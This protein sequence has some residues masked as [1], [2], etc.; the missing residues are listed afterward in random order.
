MKH[1]RLISIAI[2]ASVVLL[3]F[4]PTSCRKTAGTSHTDAADTVGLKDSADRIYNAVIHC[5]N[6]NLHDS[7]V[8]LVPK[9]ME[10]YQRLGLWKAFYNAWCK[11]GE[12]Y[13]WSGEPDSA[14]MEAQ[15]IH[16]HAKDRGDEYGLAIADYIKGLVYDMQ[17]NNTESAR[18][19]EQALNR[20]KDEDHHLKNNIFLYYLFELKTLRDTL[21]MGQAFERWDQMIKTLTG[22]SKDWEEDV[23]LYRY[24]Y[25]SSLVR[26]SFLKKDHHQAALAID[27]VSKYMEKLGWNAVTRN[28]V[29]SYRMM[30]AKLEGD[31]KTALKINDEMM[32]GSDQMEKAAQLNLF[33]ERYEILALQEN[34][35]DAYDCLMNW[36]SMSDSIRTAETNEQ[37]NTLNKRFELDELKMQAER[38]RMESRQRQLLLIIAIVAIV[39]AAVV[40]YVISRLRTARRMSEMKAA[41]E[42]IESELRIA[43]DIQMSMVPSVFPEREGLDMYASMTPAKEVGGDL[44]GYVLQGDSLYIGVGDVSGKGVPASLFMAQATRLFRT[45]ATQD[46]MPAEI[47]TRMNNALSGDD[48]Q[49][50]MFVTFFIGLIDLKTGHMSFCNAG[51]NPPVIGGDAD[52][53][54]FLQME[55]NAP[56]GLWPELEY[57]GEEIEN[58]KGHPLFIYTDGLNEAENNEQE[59]FGDDRLLSILRQTQFENARQVVETLDTEVQSHRNGAE[60]NDDLTMM[61]VRVK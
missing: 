14:I 16:D 39:V 52:H 25:Y 7:L 4:L 42:R 60:P 47:C 35:K 13:N 50:G 55:P 36:S 43:R 45:L 12:E 23:V 28:E 57:V 31:Y 41:Q 46:M 51:H 37:L 34:W 11:L 20:C 22:K 15:K 8:M 3:G 6:N 17:H 49:N 38:D 24:M 56:I 27:S 10:L 5:Y 30:L 33:Q 2:V 53:G 29:T 32:S 21:K 40:F 54:H 19:L 48:N 1:P 44:Y 9:S 59:Q 18:I 26:Y 58:I 61:C